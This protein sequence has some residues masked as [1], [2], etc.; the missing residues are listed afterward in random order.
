MK[1]FTV[2]GRM[3]KIGP[4]ESHDREQM[5]IAGLEYQARVQLEGHDEFHDEFEVHRQE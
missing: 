2:L 1:A 3:Q 4:R 5:A